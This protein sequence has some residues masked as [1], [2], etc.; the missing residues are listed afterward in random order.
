MKAV[1]QF[2]GGIASYDAGKYSRRVARVNEQN[3]LNEGV[4]ER[5]QVRMAS[6]LQEGRQIVDQ[7][8]S[9]FQVGEGTAL[10]ALRESA[11]ARELDLMIS[12]RNAS[13]RAAA[14]KQSGDLAYAQ[15]YSGMVGGIFSGATTL[16][17]EAAKAAS[18]GGGGG[19]GG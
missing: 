19:G 17:E 8:S 13:L 4:M 1:G 18:G 3:T 12:R 6:R 14:F 10:D 16:M 7:A 5:E 11:T 2:A 15:G 9:G